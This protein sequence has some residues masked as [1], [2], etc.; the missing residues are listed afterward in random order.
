MGKKKEG[1]VELDIKS[2][3]QCGVCPRPWGGQHCTPLPCCGAPAPPCGP[4]HP[5]SPASP[6]PAP[7]PASGVWGTMTCPVVPSS[8]L[9]P[10]PQKK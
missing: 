7:W 10:N 8:H 2:Q 5:A 4:A 9:A 3:P 6:A 1:T